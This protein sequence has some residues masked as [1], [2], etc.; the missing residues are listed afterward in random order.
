MH[1]PGVRALRL[2]TGEAGLRVGKRCNGV[3]MAD[4]GKGSNGEGTKMGYEMKRRRYRIEDRSHRIVCKLPAVNA[5]I[6]T[7]YKQRPVFSFN[8]PQPSTKLYYDVMRGCR[9]IIH[10]CMRVSFFA[11]TPAN[12]RDRERLDDSDPVLPRPGPMPRGQPSLALSSGASTR[13]RRRPRG[14][15]SW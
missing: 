14:P 2:D 7:Q 5:S 13:N 4:M 12:P 15:C 8:S 10:A 6:N 11:P 1:S 9:E 3:A